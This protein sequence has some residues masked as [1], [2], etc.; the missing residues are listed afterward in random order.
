MRRSPS[1]TTGVILSALL[2][3]VALAVPA[4]CALAEPGPTPAGEARPLRVGTT[5]HPYD[6]WTRNVVRGTDVEVVPSCPARS[7]R[8]T[9]SRGPR[10]SRRSPVWTRSS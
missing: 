2:A 4:R 9:T 7:T 5:L 1:R 6:S 3:A 8:A 10:T